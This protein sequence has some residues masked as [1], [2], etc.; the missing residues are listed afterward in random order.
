MAK[1][2]V[3]FET[4]FE[5]VMSLI[6]KEESA[7]AVCRRYR[8][9]ESALY[10]WRDIFLERGKQGLKGQ[11]TKNVS[12]I[13][14]LKRDLDEHKKVIADLSVVNSVLKKSLEHSS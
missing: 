1:K 9:S 6:R 4:K 7:V 2:D 5:A 10:R 3:P 14:Q 12:E 11:Q 8:V 13:N